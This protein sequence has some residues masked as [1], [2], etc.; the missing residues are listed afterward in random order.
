MKVTAINYTIFKLAFHKFPHDKKLNSSINIYN[1]TRTLNNIFNK[2]AIV[3]ANE[4]LFSLA[5]H[6]N[7]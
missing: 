6:R 2:A 3:V 1:C 4:L 7:I 5:I